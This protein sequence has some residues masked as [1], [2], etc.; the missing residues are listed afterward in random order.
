MS[1]EAQKEVLICQLVKDFGEYC[2]KVCALLFRKG[3]QSFQEIVRELSL[4]RQS[5]K[6]ALMVLLHHHLVWYTEEEEG[7]IRVIEKTF[8]HLNTDGILMRINYPK[9]IHYTK[10]NFGEYG[11]QIILEIIQNGRL[12]LDQAVRQVYFVQKQL[13]GYIPNE[14]EEAENIKNIFLLLVQHRYLM[15]ADIQTPTNLKQ[16]SSETKEG[17]SKKS[18]LSKAAQSDAKNSNGKRPNSELDPSKQT[19]FEETFWRLNPDRYVIAFS[20][21]ACIDLVSEKIHP[22]ASTILRAMFRLTEPHLKSYKDQTSSLCDQLP[23]ISN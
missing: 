2:E 18:N 14:F 15:R 4:P 9:I 1:N 7:E 20:H 23:K 19:T 5:M 8:Y 17:A 16:N 21:Q 3:K 13:R 6:K 12:T 10:Q 22:I 11:E